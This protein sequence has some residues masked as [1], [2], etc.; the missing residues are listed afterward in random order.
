M[1]TTVRYQLF[2]ASRRY[3][4]GNSAPFIVKHGL[5]ASRSELLLGLF[6]VGLSLIGAW[7]SC[8]CRADFLALEQD[9]VVVEGQVLKLWATGRK[10]RTYHLLCEY[11]VQTDSGAS[12]VER[13]VCVRQETYGQ[14]R[15]GEP[16]VVRYCRADSANFLVEGQVS[17]VFS[18]AG[19]LVAALIVL[20]LVALL[21]CIN[22][23]EWWATRRLLRHA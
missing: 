21:G 6:L 17:R 23:W 10:G 13:E 3:N 12:I 19:A 18:S 14:L 16:V 2:I 20:G 1:A 15:V 4:A 22:L 5:I 8:K 11:P 7:Y 9:P